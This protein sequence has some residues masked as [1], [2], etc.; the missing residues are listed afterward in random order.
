M[1]DLP[2][3]TLATNVD[4]GRL[5]TMARSSPCR[6]QRRTSHGA[7]GIAPTAAPPNIDAG[8]SQD[9]GAV[10]LQFVR[11]LWLMASCE[12]TASTHTSRSVAG[13]G[14]DHPRRPRQGR[15]VAFVALHSWEDGVGEKTESA[16]IG[17]TA[18]GSGR[19]RWQSP[20][21]FQETEGDE[22]PGGGG[23]GSGPAAVLG[24]ADA[25]VRTRPAAVDRRTDSARSLV[26]RRSTRR[27][28]G[29]DPI[30]P[31]NGHG[32]DRMDAAPANGPAPTE[33]AGR[34]RI[35]PGVTVNTRSPARQILDPC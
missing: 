34:C 9:R 29:G 17:G 5:S 26:I 1:I 30:T 18:G 16:F 22:T 6:W 10:Y 20:H 14:R 19:T 12:D 32:A 21:Q 25:D 33:R 15:G 35:H 24:R 2:C 3:S 11:R 27:G 31:R 8:R 28:R 13:S 23:T 4:G 7:A